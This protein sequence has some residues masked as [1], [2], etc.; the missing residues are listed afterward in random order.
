MC[1]KLYCPWSKA[2]K[3]CP[4]YSYISQ[5]WIGLIAYEYQDNALLKMIVNKLPYPEAGAVF[6]EDLVE[7]HSLEIEEDDWSEEGEE[8]ETE[9]HLTYDS[10]IELWVFLLNQY[11]PD[12]QLE[13]ISPALVSTEKKQK[14]YLPKGSTIEGSIESYA[15]QRGGLQIPGYGVWDDYEGEF[16]MNC[17]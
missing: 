11:N 14:K 5:P 6:L 15:G 17:N 16:F 12:L 7:K 9:I 8:D 10:L 3:G 2:F 4:R 13:V 1:S